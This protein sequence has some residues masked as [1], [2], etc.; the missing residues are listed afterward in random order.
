[1]TR[2]MIGAAPDPAIGMLA[3]GEALVSGRGRGLDH[4]VGGL[5]GSASGAQ[6]RGDRPPGR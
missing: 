3:L 5:A 2:Q 6:H 4:D 1:M